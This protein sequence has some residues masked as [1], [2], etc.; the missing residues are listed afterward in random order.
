MNFAQNVT[1]TE[2]ARMESDPLVVPK[3]IPPARKCALYTPTS[4]ITAARK[5]RRVITQ[6][7]T[8]HALQGHEELLRKNIQKKEERIALHNTTIIIFYKKEDYTEKRTVAET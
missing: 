2:N 4:A 1:A 5:S 7:T 3:T 6:P 8:M